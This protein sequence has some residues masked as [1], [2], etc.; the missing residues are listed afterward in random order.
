M[1]VR[2]TDAAGA[3]DEAAAEVA[4]G[5]DAFG[6]TFVNGHLALTGTGRGDRIEVQHLPAAN[7]YR[8]RPVD[9]AAR[10]GGPWTTVT[11]VTAI[12]VD[13]GDGDDVLT[14]RYSPGGGLGTAITI[15]G[16]RGNDTI[17][18]GTTT[19]VG[20]VLNGN[21][22]DDTVTGGPGDD[23]IAGGGGNDVFFFDAAETAA[24][25]AVTDFDADGSDGSSD[26]LKFRWPGADQT[27]AFGTVPVAGRF[28]YD[29]AAARLYL[30]NG[31]AVDLTG[32]TG[33]LDQDDRLF[34][35]R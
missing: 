14:F 9:P 3:T 25:Q 10:Y 2:A 6:Y 31:T 11:G 27:L 21:G 29:A 5:A 28:V 16:G 4:V 7:G 33:P 12:T 26:K 8:F 19:N 34:G 18:A 13:G 35:D 23:V 15:D 17:T 20:Y 1:A 30:P 24:D 22:G 32:I